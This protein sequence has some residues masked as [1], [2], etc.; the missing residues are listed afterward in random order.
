MFGVYAI[1]DGVVTLMTGFVSSKYSSRWWVFLLEGVI[2]IAA[3]VIAILRPGLAGFVLIAVI[4][5]WA[6]LTGILEIA[7]AI[8]LRREI[9]NEWMLAFAG[10]VS[11]V[12]GVLLFFQPAAGGLVITLMIGA[13]ALI[14]GIM[15][16]ILGFRLRKFDTLPRRP[17]QRPVQSAR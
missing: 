7:A 3:G 6:I 2:S 16:V 14:F 10:F 12:L 11:I 1:L 15:L 9:T 5:I 13:Y 4:A 17:D 8:R